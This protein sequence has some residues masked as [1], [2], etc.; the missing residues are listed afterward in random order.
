MTPD[1]DSRDRKVK[2][3]GAV[4][5]TLTYQRDWQE[6]SNVCRMEE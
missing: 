2:G 1:D 3:Y 5:I 4:L 6:V